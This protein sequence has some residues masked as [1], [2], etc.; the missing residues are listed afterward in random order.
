MVFISHRGLQVSITFLLLEGRSFW[1]VKYGVTKIL[2][3]N[4]QISMTLYSE[5]NWVSVYLEAIRAI[6]HKGGYE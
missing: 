2:P 3:R 6:F 4:F 1:I 5:E